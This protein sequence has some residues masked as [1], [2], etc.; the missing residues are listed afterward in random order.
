MNV[1]TVNN[2]ELQIKEWN[3]ERVVTFDDIDKVHNRK[4][5]TASRNF[6]KNRDR[7][8]NGKDYF[9][10]KKANIEIDEKRRFEI[11]KENISSNRGM[12]FLTK[13]GYLMIVKSMNDDKAWEVQRQLVNA[14]FMLEKIVEDKKKK[15][16]NEML[17]VQ[18]TDLSLEFKKFMEFETKKNEEF[19]ETMLKGFSTMANLIVNQNKLIEQ[20]LNGKIDCQPGIESVKPEPVVIIHNVEVDNNYKEWKNKINSLL[21]GRKDRNYLLSETYKYMTKKYGIC[22]EQLGKEF[23]AEYGRVAKRNLDL[24]YFMEKKNSCYENLTY[25]CLDTI[26][27]REPVVTVLTFPVRNTAELKTCSEYLIEKIGDKS[28]NGAVFFRKFFRFVDTNEDIKWEKF[29]N[30]YRNDMNYHGKY[31]RVSKLMMMDHSPTVEK[32]CIPLFNEYVKETYGDLIKE[33]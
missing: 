3:G 6:R 13:S 15:Q 2:V 5:G 17:V 22:W 26:I 21:A 24:A 28:P 33:V 27:N 23:L 14:Y 30:K 11:T 1:L 29:E 12:I 19:R 25:S 4:K 9:N 16:K 20:L 32:K 18:P 7:L 10:L 8:I 31:K